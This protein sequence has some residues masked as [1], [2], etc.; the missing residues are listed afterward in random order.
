MV[1]KKNLVMNLNSKTRVVI[2]SHFTF[3][4]DEKTEVF[5][6]NIRNFLIKKIG[7]L[8]YIDH[9]FIKSQGVSSDFTAS[10]MRVYE[11]GIKVSQATTPRIALPSVLLF[12]Y[13][14]FIT[15]FFLLCRPLRYDLCIACDNLSAISV[16]VL[17]KIGLIN[18]LVYYT[19]DYSPKRYSN[20]LLNN[21]Y[22]YMDR[23]AS[24]I[25]DV[26]WVAVQNMIEAKAKNGLNLQRS[27]PFQVVPIGFNKEEV[28]VKSLKK[29]SRYNLFFVGFLFKKQGL[30]LAINILPSLI[31]KFPKINLTVIGSGPYESQIKKRVKENKLS[32]HVKF[33]GYI[34][35]HQEIVKYLANQGGIGLATY[36]PSIGGYTYFA[37]PS[38]IKLYLAC[39]L[40]VITTKVPPVAIEIVKREAGLVID[41]SEKDLEDNL[42]ILL[43]NEKDYIRFRNN[44]LRMAEDYDTDLILDRAFRKLP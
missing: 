4:E 36:I 12:I 6:G 24:M 43:K 15:I 39:G 16:F 42:T 20:P 22:H 34:N 23:V 18:R 26:N 2:I 44:A 3:K 31:K 21:L 28:P 29:V 33:T 32:S 30:Q 7:R 40:P 5:P 17:R 19:V 25:S 10:Q 14:F 37:D 13:Q 9:P 11:N 27:A 8:T 38:K 41:Y 35:N 1:F